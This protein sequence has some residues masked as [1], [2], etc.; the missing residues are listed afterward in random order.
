MQKKCNFAVKTKK[1]RKNSIGL[2]EKAHPHESNEERE[3]ERADKTN[4]QINV[5]LYCHI[6]AIDQQETVIE[7][8][9]NK[10]DYK[11]ERAETKVDECTFM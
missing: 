1:S 8:R 11:R 4:K 7:E 9:S 10:G 2:R 3:R 5:L 6:R